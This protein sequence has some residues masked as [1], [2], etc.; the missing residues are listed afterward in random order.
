MQQATYKG[1]VLCVLNQEF[2]FFVHEYWGS[3][4]THLG[5]SISSYETSSTRK[6][7]AKAVPEMDSLMQWEQYHVRTTLRTLKLPLQSI[8]SEEGLHYRLGVKR[9][10]AVIRQAT[11]AIYGMGTL[12]IPLQSIRSKEG[13]Y[14]CLG[15]KR[16]EAVIWQAAINLF[17]SL[18]ILW[19]FHTRA[20]LRSLANARKCQFKESEEE[21]YESCSVQRTFTAETFGKRQKRENSTV[22]MLLP[23]SHEL[24]ASRNPCIL[25]QK[26]G[27][28][29]TMY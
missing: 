15:A 26:H 27:G 25:F 11:N 9:E 24:L 28:A 3:E 21:R 12:K 1:S 16:K 6:P 8:R 29:C 22:V 23:G 14:Y 10:K 2:L 18:D 5:W 4:V 7:C 13:P 17:T 20:V 19:W